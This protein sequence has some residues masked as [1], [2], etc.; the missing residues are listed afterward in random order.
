M[1]KLPVLLSPRH[2]LHRPLLCVRRS[3][4]PQCA[5]FSC[6]HRSD[7]KQYGESGATISFHKFPVNKPALLKQ[8]IYKIGR[9]G[10]T[11]SRFAVLCSAHFSAD[12]YE[13]DVHEKYGVPGH[14]ATRG[15]DDWWTGQCPR[16]SRTHR[17]R[18][19]TREAPK[20]KP[21]R[22]QLTLSPPPTLPLATLAVLVAV[23]LR[24]RRD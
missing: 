5:A 14:V 10:F 1:R 19:L 23:Q 22:P 24:R 7:Q 4:M 8:W 18:A 11:P 15:D 17:T 2:S 12:C 3:T 9:S 6:T 16:C 13:I 20:A 21:R